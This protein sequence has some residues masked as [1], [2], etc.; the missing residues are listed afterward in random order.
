MNSYRKKK[1]PDKILDTIII[2]KWNLEV[3]MQHVQDNTARCMHNYKTHCV[4]VYESI[5]M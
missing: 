5:Y 2:N 3:P 1:I 4:K